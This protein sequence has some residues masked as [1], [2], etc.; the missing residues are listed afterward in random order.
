MKAVHNIQLYNFIFI[1][2]YCVCLNSKTFST[3]YQCTD[4]SKNSVSALYRDH[5]STDQIHLTS[6]H[7]VYFCLKEIPRDMRPRQRNKRMTMNMDTTIS[8]QPISIKENLALS[9]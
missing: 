2:K 6:A 3:V 5:S 1:D 8:R 7:T 9:L 4:T